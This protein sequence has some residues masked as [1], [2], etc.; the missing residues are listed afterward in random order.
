MNYS[1]ITNTYLKVGIGLVQIEKF[2]SITT[3]I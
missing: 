3:D 2:T 1:D